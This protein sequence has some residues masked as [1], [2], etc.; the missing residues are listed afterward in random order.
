MKYLR[1]DKMNKKT[2]IIVCTIIL[3]LL[4]VAG[5]GAIQ[6]NN[7]IDN[8]IEKKTVTK[9]AMW[10]SFSFESAVDQAT[11]IVYGKVVDKSNTKI[12]QTTSSSGNI[13]TECYKEVSIEVIDILKGNMDGNTVTYLEWGGETEDT[14]YIFAGMTPVEINDEYIF[15]LNQYGAFLSPMTLLPVEDGTVL[16]KGKIAPDSQTNQETRTID[17]SVETYLEAIKSGLK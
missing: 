15:F 6:K 10:P 17:I 5:I 12:H 1:G 9:T 11:T 2:T 8:N 14:I 4:V 16:T 3:A 13:Y 7:N